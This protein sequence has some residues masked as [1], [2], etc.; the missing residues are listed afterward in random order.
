MVN[1]TP[2]L[3]SNRLSPM[4]AV[5]EQME[6]WFGLDREHLDSAIMTNDE[7]PSRGKGHCSITLSFSLPSSIVRLL[8][9]IHT[10][11]T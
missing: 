10:D 11:P 3:L 5:S 9:P 7:N 4:C 6:G 8:S 1:G 2:Q